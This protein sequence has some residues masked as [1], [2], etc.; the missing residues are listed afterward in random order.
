MLAEE[1]L[2]RKKLAQDVVG[3]LDG[4]HSPGASGRVEA[5]VQELQRMGHTPQIVAKEPGRCAPAD[6]SP[7]MPIPDSAFWSDL[8]RSTLAS[9]DE[10]PLRQVAARLIKPRNQWPV[11]ELIER[12]VAAVENPAVL[13]RR[14]ADLTPRRAACSL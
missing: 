14:L 6:R 8:L 7:T 9:Y 13:D 11:E 10:A 2:A 4:A 12:C 1:L 3:R 5:V